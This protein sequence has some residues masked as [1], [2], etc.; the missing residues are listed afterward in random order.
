MVYTE[1]IFYS[2]TTISPKLQHPSKSFVSYF[3]EVLFKLWKGFLAVD[4]KYEQELE[5]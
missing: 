3:F 4:M 5:C 2:D 1:A